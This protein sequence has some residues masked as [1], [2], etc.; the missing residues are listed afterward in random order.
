MKS[1]CPSNLGLTLDGAVDGIRYLLIPDLSKLWNP[2]VWSMAGSQVMFSYVSGQGV[3]TSL[4]S[5][6]KPTFNVFKEKL[7]IKSDVFSILH[8]FINKLLEG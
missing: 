6:N 2:E 8:I 5:F 7:K 3:L 4:G 1:N